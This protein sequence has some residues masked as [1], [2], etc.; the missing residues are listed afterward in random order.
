LRSEGEVVDLH[1][2]GR[3]LCPSDKDAAR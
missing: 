1:G 3:S 2:A